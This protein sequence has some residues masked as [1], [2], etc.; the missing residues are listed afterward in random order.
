MEISNKIVL[1]TLLIL[2][3][4]V[5][6]ANA[7]SVVVIKEY[8][9]Q[10]SEFD[11]KETS[12]AI[13][14]AQVKRL[15]L[16]EL[17]TYLES[18]TEVVNF[19]LTKDKITTLTAGVVQTK[20]LDEKWKNRTYWLKAKIL[21]DDAQVAKSI[22]ALR[23]D[24]SKTKELEDLKQR[25]DAQLKEIERLR[26]QL[27]VA[28]GKKRQENLVAYNKTIKELTATDWYAKGWALQYSGRHNDA[29]AAHSK[30]IELDPLYAQAYNMRGASYASLGNLNQAIQDHNR[31]IEL[32]PQYAAA[33]SNRGVAYAQMGNS[34]QAINDF[35]RAI[36]LDPEFAG[37]YA[38][39]GTLYHNFGNYRQAI[40]DFDKAIEI[41]SPIYNEKG[42]EVEVRS[43][44][45]AMY[46]NR[47]TSYREL[48]NF[49]QALQDY[50]RAIELN[51]NDATFYWN[52]GALYGQN[53]QDANRGLLDVKQ[54]AR[55][56]LKA[57]QDL[58]RRFN[59]SW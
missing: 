35:G 2:S 5:Q 42:S 37:V 49:R 32:D 26:A 31:A 30:A 41:Y 45:A 17:G 29:I 46:S 50:D 53:L 38:N 47:G 33:Y 56:G 43:T 7:T 8:T 28:K 12:R 9:Y 59:Y 54:A 3:L 27:S 20:I 44:F 24:R 58:L 11:T 55:L 34:R 10:A 16:E 18:D 1:C 14:L 25:T 21:A 36:D 4:F 51:P 48:G 52:R 6:P 13:A 23:R 39:R 15:V 22:D 19:Q 57:A 40:N